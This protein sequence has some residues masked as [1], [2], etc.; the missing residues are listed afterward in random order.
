MTLSHRDRERLG[1]AILG[2]AAVVAAWGLVDDL[3]ISLDVA[4]TPAPGWFRDQLGFDYGKG[5]SGLPENLVYNPGD[6][7]PLRRLVSSFL[8]PLATAFMLVAL[9]LAA[10]WRGAAGTCAAALLAAGLLWTHSRSVYRALAVG[11]AVLAYGRAPG[12]RSP[13][14]RFSSQLR[15]SSSGPIPT[16]RP[17]RGSRGRSSRSSGRRQGG[18][19][20]RR[21]ARSR[22][23]PSGAT[24][25]ACVKGSRRSSSSRTATDSATRG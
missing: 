20:E 11:L 13:R 15:S 16:S 18:G 24:W 8:S 14:R 6:E 1:W 2:V 4:S 21:A 25:T 19:D 17:R 5:L 10:T 23:R 22:R 7:G 12:G 3:P 9:V